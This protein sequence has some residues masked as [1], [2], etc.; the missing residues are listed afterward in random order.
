M[1]LGRNPEFFRQ[2]EKNLGLIKSNDGGDGGL[3]EHQRNGSTSPPVALS[4]MR[5]V[6]PPT[7]YRNGS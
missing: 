7:T 1:L 6:P 4:G 3:R 2:K 5:A